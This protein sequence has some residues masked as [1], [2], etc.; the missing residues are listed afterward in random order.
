MKQEHRRDNIIPKL[1]EANPDFIPR[2]LTA[3]L[4]S[5]TIRRGFAGRVFV[6]RGFAARGFV[7]RGF[8][9][10]NTFTLFPGL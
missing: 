3:R 6:G 7:G 2:R 10:D 8:S 1:V 5:A 9:R 4:H